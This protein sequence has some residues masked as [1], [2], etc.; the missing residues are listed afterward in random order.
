MCH[1]EIQM[2]NDTS[3]DMVLGTDSTTVMIGQNWVKEGRRVGRLFLYHEG[4]YKKVSHRVT[5][6]RSQSSTRRALNLTDDIPLCGKLHYI[7]D[8]P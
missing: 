4:A 5:G 6:S 2:S 3:D 7:K 8:A 1:R